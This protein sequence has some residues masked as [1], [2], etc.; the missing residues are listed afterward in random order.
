MTLKKT[1]PYDSIV[2]YIIHLSAH[3][4]TLIYYADTF[5]EMYRHLNP[6]MID[7][8]IDELQAIRDKFWVKREN[9]KES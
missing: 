8:R 3:I 7:D 2:Y 6:S 4:D 1:E 9:E 5:P